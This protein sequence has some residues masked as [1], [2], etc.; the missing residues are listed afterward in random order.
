MAFELSNILISLSATSTVI[1]L[2][3]KHCLVNSETIAIMLGCFLYFKIAFK[4][5]S[6]FSEKGSK[7]PNFGILRLITTFE[8]KSF[9]FI[10]NYSSFVIRVS[11]SSIRFI[12]SED[13]T[14]FDK[15]GLTALQ[16]FAFSYVL[17][18]TKQTW[19]FPVQLINVKKTGK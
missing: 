5:W 19:L 17:F 9:S 18:I 1:V 10:A 4:G 16:K 2:K 8:K 6:M 3:E 15:K 11:S 13:C 7:L 14:L 12:L